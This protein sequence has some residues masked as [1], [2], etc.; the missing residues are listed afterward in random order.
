MTGV[1]TGQMP[2]EPFLL[3]VFFY[4]SLVFFFLTLPLSL[5]SPSVSLVSLSLYIFLSVSLCFSQS[6]CLSV[7]LSLSLSLSV[8]GVN[9]QRVAVAQPTENKRTH[10]L[11]IGLINSSSEEGG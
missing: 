5:P 11:I 10:Q 4:L 3:C 9:E 7:C 8:F 2:P 6:V 1:K